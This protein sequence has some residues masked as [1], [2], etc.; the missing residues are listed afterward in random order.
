MA[1]L[2]GADGLHLVPIPYPNK[3]YDDYL[4]ATLTHDDYPELIAAGESVNTVAVGAV[5]IAYNW[6]KTNVDRY[7]RVQRFVEAFFPK[8]TELQKP[9]RHVKWREVNLTATLPGWKRFDAAQAWLDQHASPDANSNPSSAAEQATGPGQVAASTGVRSAGG[10]AG[11][12]LP[13][14][15][16]ALYQEFLKWRQAR[17]R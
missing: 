14:R 11:Q 10:G 12:P 4:P 2:S 15:N 3:L 8:I 6:P 5:L 16:S 7:E 13:D 1:K 9:P 17:G